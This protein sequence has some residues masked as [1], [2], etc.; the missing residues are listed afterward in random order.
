MAENI[1]H[2]NKS[3][4]NKKAKKAKEEHHEHGE[5]CNHEGHS[6]AQAPAPE[7]DFMAKFSKL[8]GGD[9]NID[10]GNFDNHITDIKAEITGI[11]AV[12]DDINSGKFNLIP[13]PEKE[14]KKLK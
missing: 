3:K 8:L 7:T 1:P 10:F 14:R 13:E 9:T 12:L 11:R 5:H 2:D 6:H 4:K